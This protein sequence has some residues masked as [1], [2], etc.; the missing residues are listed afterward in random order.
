MA[1]NQRSQHMKVKRK[2]KKKRFWLTFSLSLLFILILSTIGYGFSLWNSAA[3][4]VTDSYESDGREDGSELRD[5]TVELDDENIS[6]LFIGVDQGGGREINEHGLSDSL[7]LTTLNKSDK[8]VKM[9]SIPR[10]SYVYVPERDTYT[11]I[12][13]AHAYGG[14]KATIETVENLFDLP[15]DYFV[16]INFNAF[17]DVVDALGGIEYD[18]PFEMYEMDSDD[19][20]NAIHLLPGEQMLDGEE[21]LAVARTRKY[22][23]DLE[24]GKRQ[25]EVLNAIFDRA[26]SLNTVFNVN[27]IFDAVGNNMTTNLAFSDMTRLSSRFLSKDLTIESINLEGRDMMKDLYYYDIDDD[28]LEEVST[29]LRNHLELD[30]AEATE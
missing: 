17:I 22:D 10:D 2:R 26:L 9:V 27:N 19:N 1:T 25:Q 24:R 21:A 4:M 23:N 3:N 18:V 30:K 13:H 11:K 8:S 29:E 28:H 6:I 20:K 5:D 12:T 7:I 16:K 14:P 15:V